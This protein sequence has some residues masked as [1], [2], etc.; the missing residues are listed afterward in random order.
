MIQGQD[1]V[2]LDCN[3]SLYIK[4]DSDMKITDLCIQEAPDKELCF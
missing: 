4:M 1:Y 3:L 2:S